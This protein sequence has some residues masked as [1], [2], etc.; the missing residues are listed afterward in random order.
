MVGGAYY[1]RIG[2]GLDGGG[3]EFAIRL[4]PIQAPIGASASL[5]AKYIAIQVFFKF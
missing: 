4:T 3:P 5:H 2:E 1:P